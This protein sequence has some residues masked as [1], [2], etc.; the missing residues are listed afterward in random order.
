MSSNFH[1]L[2]TVCSFPLTEAIKAR[3]KKE[4]DLEETGL[5]HDSMDENAGEQTL[6]PDLE[7]ESGED[8][9]MHLKRHEHWNLKCDKPDAEP[10]PEPELTPPEPEQGSGSLR[11]ATTTARK[12][13]SHE[14]APTISPLEEEDSSEEHLTL[15]LEPEPELHPSDDVHSE[16][17]Y[18]T[19]P[20][21]RQNDQHGDR[22][23]ASTKSPPRA[24]TPPRYVA[25]CQVHFYCRPWGVWSCLVV[26][27]WTRSR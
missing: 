6:K 4:F 5:A 27:I 17:N 26:L 20:R 14:R 7:P 23:D 2:T 9:L 16:P 22:S 13:L 3:F 12:R 19:S 11:R 24:H 1:P 21:W 25:Q 8:K 10:Q 15:E 18:N